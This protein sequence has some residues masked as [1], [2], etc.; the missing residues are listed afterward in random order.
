MLLRTANLW[1]IP[2][3]PGYGDKDANVTYAA[4][5]RA[6]STWE[7]LETNLAVLYARF[8]GV[9][10]KEATSR[11]EYAN[12][13]TFRGRSNQ[14]R[15]AACLF[16][17]RHSSQHLEGYFDNLISELTKVA[18]RRNDIAHGVVTF[19]PGGTADLEE[20]L[21]RMEYMLVPSGYAVKKYGATGDPT[22]MYSSVELDH[23]TQ[24]FRLYL[25]RVESSGHDP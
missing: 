4:V 1:D 2:P 8:L 24:V 19:W 3:Y 22:Y 9:S 16:F 17:V 5:G 18:D 10:P 20:A 6:L 13:G 21:R 7:E 11:S 23:F 25:S 15:E 12:A 14:V